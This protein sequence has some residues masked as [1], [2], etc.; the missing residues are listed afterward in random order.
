MRF[1]QLERRTSDEDRVQFEEIKGFVA[2]EL[3]R[4][5]DRMPKPW[6]EDLVETVTR[7]RIRFSRQT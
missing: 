7:L 3:G 5:G 4:V 1:E 6:F 2:G